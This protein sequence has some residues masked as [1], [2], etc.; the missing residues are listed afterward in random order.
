[1]ANAAGLHLTEALEC[2]TYRLQSAGRLLTQLSRRSEVLGV[3]VILAST[4]QSRA[5][6]MSLKARC[7]REFCRRVGHARR[8]LLRPDVSRKRIGEPRL[9]CEFLDTARVP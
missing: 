6:V 8:A 1:M 4:H 2:A 5:V 7:S 3:D 9:D